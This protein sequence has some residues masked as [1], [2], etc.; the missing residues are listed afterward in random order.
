MVSTLVKVEVLK[1]IKLMDGFSGVL[2][3]T[4]AYAYRIKYPNGKMLYK[5][6]YGNVG[7]VCGFVNCEDVR[8]LRVIE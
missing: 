7:S 5:V 8:E 2:K 3:G 6:Y 1:D 4:E